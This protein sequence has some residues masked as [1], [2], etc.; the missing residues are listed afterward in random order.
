MCAPN[1]NK[2]VLG[3]NVCLT[4]SCETIEET[5]ALFNKLKEGGKVLY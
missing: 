1:G 4:V 3:D 5:T 2:V